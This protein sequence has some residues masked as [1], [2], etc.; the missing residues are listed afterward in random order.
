MKLTVC[1]LGSGWTGDAREQDTLM[2]HIDAEQSNLLLLPEMPF[3][4][5]LSGTRE[6]DEKKWQEAVDAHAA[7]AER[8]GDFGVPMIAG[9]RPVL[10]DNVPHNEAFVW[11]A[12]SGIMGV[13]EKYYLPDEEGFWEASWYRRGDG[14]FEICRVNG[15]S[16]GFLICTEMWFNHRAR[17][18]GKEGMEILLC[19]RATPAASSSAWVAGGRAAAK[20]SGA[21]CLSSNFNGM[22][23]P[24]MDFGGTAWIIEPENGDVLGTTTAKSPFLTLDVDLA[25]ARAAKQTYPRYVED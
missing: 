6:P 21:F 1:E 15:V 22:N 19:P 16:V 10:K 13:H 3:Y 23:I 8:L 20:V 9:T 17:D 4:T 7:W 12:E 25:D 2:A 18:Y 5:W 11:T 24:G 14:V